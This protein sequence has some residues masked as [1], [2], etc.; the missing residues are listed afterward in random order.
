MQDQGAGRSLGGNQVG[1]G[2]SL[3]IKF[4]VF[5]CL[6][7]HTQHVQSASQKQSSQHDGSEPA[8]Q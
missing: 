3:G 5:R 1:G 4:L 8:K 7:D 2:N 6:R